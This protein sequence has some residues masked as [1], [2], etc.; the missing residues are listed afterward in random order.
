VVQGLGTSRVDGHCQAPWLLGETLTLQRDQL[1][2]QLG[3]QVVDA[4]VTDVFQGVERH[5][6]A[7]ASHACEHDHIAMGWAWLGN[8]V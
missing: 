2:Q 5:T 7:R 8:G 3:R 4:V 6:F 1:G